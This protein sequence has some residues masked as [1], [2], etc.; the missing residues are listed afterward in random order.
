MEARNEIRERIDGKIEIE[1]PRE[2]V[3]KSP[4]RPK[5]GALAEFPIHVR[6]TRDQY[7]MIKLRAVRMSISISESLRQILNS[8]GSENDE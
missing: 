5:I 2:S 6:L 8:R 1:K 4:G 7:R 3:K